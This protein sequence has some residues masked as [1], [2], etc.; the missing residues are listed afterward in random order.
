MLMLTFWGS[1]RSRTCDGVS[2]RDFLKVGAL[3]LSGLTLADLLR[4][5]AGAAP[6]GPKKSVVMVY[7]YGGPS[8]IDTYDLKPDAPAEYRGEFK[9]IATN[10]PGFDICELMPLQAK[11]ADKLALIRNMKFNPNFHDPVE[12]FSG[13]RKPGILTPAVRPDLGSVVSYLRRGGAQVLPPYVALDKR[14][15]GEFLNGPAYLG[16]AHKF[17]VAG[18]ELEAL[19]PARDVTLDRL[20]GRRGL[21][22]TFDGLRRSVD[23]A[24]DMITSSQVR[25]AFDVTREPE[26]VRSHYGANVKLLRARRLVEAG[27]PVVTL[28]LSLG[29]D[30]NACKAG[31]DTHENNF[32]CLRRMVP[33]LDHGVHALVTDLHERGL[34]K[35]VAVVVWGEMGRHP[36]IGA[37]GMSTP[38]GRDHWVQSGFALLAGGGLKTGQVIG[39]TTARAE[40]PR[41][42][43][44]TPQHVLATLYHVL[45]IDAANTTVPD[46]SGRPIYLLDAPEKV[47]ELV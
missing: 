10:V 39:A 44:Y 28:T 6:G 20:E 21:L 12:L 38:T 26:R 16:H 1:D 5:R 14:A 7:L 35:D 34:D 32:P 25:D 29:Y 47:T 23:R 33:R 30:V 43:A 18:E 4:L 36:M 11:I 17:F 22:R 24:L 45:G 19:Q 37:G 3:G 9:P 13:F 27:V 15:G 41:D 40:R 31:W 46:R 8:H 2:R 42:T